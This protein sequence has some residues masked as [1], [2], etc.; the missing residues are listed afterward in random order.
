MFCQQNSNC[1]INNCL[2]LKTDQLTTLPTWLSFT[3]ATN[4][5]PKHSSPEQWRAGDGLWHPHLQLQTFLSCR[6]RSH[7]QCSK[8][9]GWQLRSP[10]LHRQSVF[11][12]LWITSC[13]KHLQRVWRTWKGLWNTMGRARILLSF[14]FALYFQAFLSHQDPELPSRGVRGG[15]GCLL[16]RRCLVLTAPIP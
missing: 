2:G 8:G 3:M 13:I 10:L 7:S 9:Q 5:I 16:P 1:F 12:A 11:P 15:G 4:S 6:R 14:G